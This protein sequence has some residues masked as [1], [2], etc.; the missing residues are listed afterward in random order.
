MR[1]K[2]WLTLIALALVWGSSFFF[3]EIA[4]V[5]LTTLMIVLIRVTLAALVLWSI[6]LVARMKVPRHLSV[7]GSLFLMALFNNTLPFSLI[8]W[9][10]HYITAGLASLLNATTPIFAVVLASLFLRDEKITLNKA[11]GIMLGFVGTLIMIG[12]AVLAGLNLNVLAQLAGMGAALSYAIAGV[13]GRRFL[14]H[15]INNPVVIAACQ[16]SLSALMLSLAVWWSGD[17][18]VDAWPTTP[19]IL[20]LLCLALL[21]TALAYVLYFK[22]LESAGVTNL[23]LVTFLIPVSAILLGIGL[24][25]ESLLATHIAGMVVIALSLITIDGRAWR[26]LRGKA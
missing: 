10:Q 11:I 24:L 3:V 8:V 22:L 7:W 9:G 17:W 26:I 20:S 13:Y 15:S 21:S 16:L 2:D 19:T 5:E 6:V 14:S 18:Y 23:L 25:G 12:P 4:I 1:L